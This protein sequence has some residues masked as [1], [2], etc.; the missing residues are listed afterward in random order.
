MEIFHKLG[1]VFQHGGVGYR[2]EAEALRDVTL[3]LLGHPTCICG[4]L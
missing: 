2:L 1:P 3:S 4:L